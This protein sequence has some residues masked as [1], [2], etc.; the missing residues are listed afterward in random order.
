M[1]KRRESEMEEEEEVEEVEEVEEE[2]EEDALV[3]Y[4]ESEEETATTKVFIEESAVFE[5]VTVED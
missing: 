5:A 2:G 1:R 3:D 4:E